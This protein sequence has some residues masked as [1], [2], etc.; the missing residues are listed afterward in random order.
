MRLQARV[1]RVVDLRTFVRVEAQDGGCGRCHEAGGCRSDMLG[2][3]FGPRCREYE[4]ENAT[5]AVP[6]S[7]VTVEVPDGIPWRAAMLAYGLPLFALLAGALV[8]VWS[9]ASEPFVIVSSL[10][11]LVCST[12]LLRAPRIRAWLRSVRPRLV[13]I[14]ES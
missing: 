9:G 11:A 1:T 5:G 4:V 3:V 2:D 7:R 8:A 13:E 10:G 12:L 14:L 6:G